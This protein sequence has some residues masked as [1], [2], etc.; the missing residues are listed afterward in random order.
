MTV[1]D[2][3]KVVSLLTIILTWEVIVEVDGMAKN[4]L[5]GVLVVCAFRI[6]DIRLLIPPSYVPANDIDQPLLPSNT[7]DHSG[8]DVRPA[9]LA[10]VKFRSFAIVTISVLFML[11]PILWFSVVPAS[12][13]SQKISLL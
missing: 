1:S 10:D 13:Q 8:S 11:L 12:F 3:L 2:A 4:I 9:P 7:Y 5:H 6:R